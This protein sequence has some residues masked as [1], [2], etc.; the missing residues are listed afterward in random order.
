MVGGEINAQPAE[1]INK[2]NA[3]SVSHHYLLYR[4]LQSL[5][6]LRVAGEGAG[7]VAGVRHQAAGDGQH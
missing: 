7:V 4:D 5:T 1:N 6:E 3:V 2:I